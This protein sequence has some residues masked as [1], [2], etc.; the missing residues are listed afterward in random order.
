MPEHKA[1]H[2]QNCLNL[3]NKQFFKL[4]SFK[5]DKNSGGF[6]FE[7]KQNTFPESIIHQ[8]NYRRINLECLTHNGSYNLW[9][10]RDRKDH[11]R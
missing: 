10:T 7:N 11:L 9:A 3:K 6:N 5:P 4:K 8:I 2:T 1:T